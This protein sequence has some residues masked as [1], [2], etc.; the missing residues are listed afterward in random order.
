M[1][2]TLA[3]V[4]WVVLEEPDGDHRPR[5][6]DSGGT[7]SCLGLFA[8]LASA[9]GL[10]FSGEVMPHYHDAIAATLIRVLS[11]LP[12]YIVLVT[13]GAAGRPCCRGARPPRHDRLASSPSWDRSLARRE[14]ARAGALAGGVVATIIGTMPVLILPFSVFH[15]HEKVSLRA[16]GGAVLAVAGVALLML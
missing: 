7:A 15:Y 9:I 10:V 3:G 12:G 14:H 16:I 8:S 11:A 13:L 5:P 1:A 4:A 2:V 6:L